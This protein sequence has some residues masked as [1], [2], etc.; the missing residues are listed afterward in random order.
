MSELILWQLS[1]RHFRKT[2]DVSN[3]NFVF[4]IMTMRKLSSCHCI[5]DITNVSCSIFFLRKY[6]YTIIFRFKTNFSYS[7]AHLFRC[8]DFN[9]SNMSS[10][11]GNTYCLLV[12]I[13]WNLVTTYVLQNSYIYLHILSYIWILH[14][15]VRV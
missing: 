4:V 12:L 8:F 11:S 10:I 1:T 14:I 6:I 9:I 15:L 13:N 7:P 5:L 3:C 2:I